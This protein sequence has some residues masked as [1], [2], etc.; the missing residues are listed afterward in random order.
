MAVIMKSIKIK[1]KI[2]GV[3]G[4]VLLLI[5]MNSGFG[6]LKISHVGEKLQTIAEEDIP[7]T[8]AITEITI[9]QL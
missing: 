2:L 8:E 5:A 9:N 3:V 6:I 4:V 7:L 1:T